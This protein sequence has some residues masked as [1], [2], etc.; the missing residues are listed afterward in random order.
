VSTSEELLKKIEGSNRKIK[1]FGDLLDS[2]ATTDDKKKMLWKEIYQNAVT[3]REAAHALYVQLY[4]TLSGTAQEHIA[5]GPM[6]VR[7]L[8]RMGKCNEQLIKLADMITAAEKG[9][10]MTPDDMFDAI[11]G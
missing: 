2:L 7:Y 9:E 8:E 11:G 10:R 5:T 4:M 6:L 3:D 1:E